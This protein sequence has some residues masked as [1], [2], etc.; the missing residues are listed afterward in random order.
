MG[1][2]LQDLQTNQ[3]AVF[4]EE[5]S[6]PVTFGN[7]A[8][9]LAAAQSGV[10]VCDRSHWGRIRVSDSDRLRFLHNQTTNQMQ[11]LQPGQ[12]C[13]TVFVTSTGRTI[14]LVTAYVDADSVLL[15]TSPGQAEPLMQWMDRYIFFADK[16]KLTD[17]TATTVAFTIIGP[18]SPALLAQLGLSEL[19]TAPDH[20]H[21]VA[22]IAGVEVQV[23]N[24]SGLALPGF[25]L[26]AAADAGGPLWSALTDA[27]AVPLG[28]RGW[29]TLRVE[30]GRPL[31]GTE[32]TDDYNPL[33]AALWQ[34]I[35]FDKGCYIGQETIARLQ[36]YQGVKQQLWGLQLAAPVAPD[37]PI[38][39]EG[40][41]VGV[42]TS[43]V[44]TAE[45]AIALGYIRT[46]A[47]GLGLSV[48]VDNQSATVVDL[49]FASRGYLAT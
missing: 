29:Q 33:E 12:G 10:A 16:V 15:L 17:E 8:A 25:T 24:G 47:G 36:T 1:N 44:P 4:A 19:A 43:C 37:T 28:D 40:N 26:I 27:G 2:A 11:Q 45:G 5:L 18:D 31:P 41:K 9:A 46:K 14:D 38:M 34:A 13:D 21:Q 48:T 42:V 35:S 39:V 23:A 32:L 3:G 20:S 22:T 49:P 30:Q 6:V 7:D